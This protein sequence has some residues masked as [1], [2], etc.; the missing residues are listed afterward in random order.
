MEKKRKVDISAALSLSELPFFENIKSNLSAPIFTV[1]L[2]KGEPG[3]FDFGFIDE[4]K[5]TDQLKYTPVD[6]RQGYWEFNITGYQI[7]DMPVKQTSRAG[8]AGACLY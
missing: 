3:S 1:D 5:Y 4:E 6:P 8:I 2:K 7:G